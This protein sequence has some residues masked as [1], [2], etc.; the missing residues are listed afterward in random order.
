M[1]EN[2][3]LGMGWLPDL[4]DYRD[5]TPEHKRIKPMLE[6]MK[7]AEVE[8]VSLPSSADFKTMV[9]RD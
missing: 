4:P 7:L 1:A 8:K 9:L 2:K 6:E 5:Y 3:I